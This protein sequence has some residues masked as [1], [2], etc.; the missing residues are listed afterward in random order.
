MV[1][2]SDGG[3]GPPHIQLHGAAIQP[4]EDAGADAGD[5]EDPVLLQVGVA[6][7]SPGRHL[8]RGD[9]EAQRLGE[10][11]DGGQE[12]E[13]HSRKWGAI[14]IKC[15]TWGGAKLSMSGWASITWKL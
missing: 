15:R 7:E 3:E 14:G 8:R 4:A 9:E 13:F 6:V 10:Q 5:K 1:H 11:G 12:F 2:S